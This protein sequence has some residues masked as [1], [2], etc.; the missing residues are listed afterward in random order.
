M[1]PIAP[2]TA[3]AARHSGSSCT[4]GPAGEPPPHEW[5][6]ALSAEKLLR[7]DAA[8][9]SASGWHEESLMRR[10]N[11]RARTWGVVI[12]AVP[13]P[14]LRGPRALML[15]RGWAT[16]EQNQLRETPA[17]TCCGATA[18]CIGGAQEKRDRS[19]HQLRTTTTRHS[20]AGPSPCR[21]AAG[22]RSTWLPLRRPPA[23]T[24]ISRQV[25][26]Q[27]SMRPTNC[28]GQRP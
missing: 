23:P 10:G 13:E 7:Y 4:L 28:S 16:H 20:K 15:R 1:A 26:D 5:R 3:A 18:R 21:Q 11:Q 25:G 2:S 24:I 12:T 22:R 27:A 19:C 8:R 9:A 6:K 17:A 14:W